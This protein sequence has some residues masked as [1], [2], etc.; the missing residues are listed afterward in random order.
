SAAAGN[1][2]IPVVNELTRLVAAVDGSAANYV[3]WGATSQDA[4]DTGL[5]L[6][7]R[8]ALELFAIEI[9]QL[10]VDLERLAIEHKATLIAGRTWLQHAAP[11]TFGLKA[12]GWL[13]AVARNFERLCDARRR[14]FV[15]QF[16]GAAGTLASLGDQA[17]RT[18]SLLAEELHLQAAEI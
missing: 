4:M 16:G 8:Q 9:R 5:V 13:C 18:S 12:A 2:T 14:G 10:C 17:G 11:T 3:H 15:L 7:L 1:S 6:Q